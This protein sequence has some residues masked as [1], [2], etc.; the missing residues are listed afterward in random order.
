[1]CK[2][3]FMGLQVT[4]MQASMSVESVAYENETRESFLNGRFSTV[5]LLDEVTCFEKSE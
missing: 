2:W 5:G 1:M 4:N 3:A